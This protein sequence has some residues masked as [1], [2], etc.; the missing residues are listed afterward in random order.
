L[1]PD[2]RQRTAA[3]NRPLLRHHHG[4]EV[5]QSITEIGPRGAV[6][7]AG[8][9]LRFRQRRFARAQ[10]TFRFESILHFGKSREHRLLQRTQ[11][12]RFLRTPFHDFRLHAAARQD[13]FENTGAQTPDSKFTVEQIAD[14][15]SARAPAAREFQRRPYRP[16]RLLL[17]HALRGKPAFRRQHIR[18]ALQKFR[19]KSCRRRGC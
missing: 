19:R 12:F 10:E 18:T 5:A 17:P 3:L 2:R 16:A 4:Q 7:L 15:R 1:P 8:Q 13:G 14:G 9:A 6:R 11:R